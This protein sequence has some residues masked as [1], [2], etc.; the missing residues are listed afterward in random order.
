MFNTSPDVFDPA[1]LL[2]EI[3]GILQT[4]LSILPADPP[5]IFAYA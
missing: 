2:P 5:V 4:F 1:E 3:E